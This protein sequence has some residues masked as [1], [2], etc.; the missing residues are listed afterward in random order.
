MPLARFAL[1]ESGVEIH[2]AA[3]ADDGERWQSDPWSTS[4]SSRAAT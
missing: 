4:R 1:Y 3:T 2:V